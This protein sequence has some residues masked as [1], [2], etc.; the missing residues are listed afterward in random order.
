MDIKEV[1]KENRS[2][3]DNIKELNE[4]REELE[5]YLYNNIFTP[6][7]DKYYKQCMLRVYLTSYNTI[8]IELSN[9]NEVLS[10]F[11]INN[12]CLKELSTIGQ[13]TIRFNKDYLSIQY[14]SID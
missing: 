6:I 7:L 11:E 1:M 2:I 4:K 8:T 10:K 9:T 14:Y 13:Y 3:N 12:S 5:E